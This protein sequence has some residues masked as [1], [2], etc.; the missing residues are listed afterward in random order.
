MNKFKLEEQYMNV[1]NGI[2]SLVEGADL[3]FVYDEAE[4]I[5]NE[6]TSIGDKYRAMGEDPEIDPEDEY[7]HATLKLLFNLSTILLMPDEVTDQEK[8]D[9]LHEY[10]MLGP[11]ADEEIIKA[12]SVAGITPEIAVQVVMG[13]F[14]DEVGE[15]SEEVI[16]V[17]E[18]ISE[19][20]A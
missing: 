11:V 17:L 6:L 10:V 9:M 16:E 3:K 8:L 1:I 7:R 2:N 19:V 13:Y 20:E 14:Q 18:G 5:Y 4:N 12:Y 15:Y